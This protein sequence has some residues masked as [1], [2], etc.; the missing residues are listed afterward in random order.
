VNYYS[1]SG[2]NHSIRLGELMTLSHLGLR[3]LVGEHCVIEDESVVS[4]PLS[5]DISPG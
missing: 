1:V 4:S 3:S 5:G 2:L